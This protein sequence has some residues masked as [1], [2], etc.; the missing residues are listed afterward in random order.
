MFFMVVYLELWGTYY[1]C[2]GWPPIWFDVFSWIP[3]ANPPSGI[4]VI[5]F[6]F[7]AACLLA[8]KMF[9]L[10]KWHRFRQMQ[11]FKETIKV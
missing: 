9:N 6:A 5:Y 10:Q 2:W 3:S 4:G 7:D 11:Q 8:Y 1:Q